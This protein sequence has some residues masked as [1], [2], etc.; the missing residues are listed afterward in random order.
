[1]AEALIW[2]MV[3]NCLGEMHQSA[4]CLGVH[5]IEH[6]LFIVQPATRPTAAS[7]I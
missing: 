2:V 4:E 1:M 6:P 7:A 5:R 3:T